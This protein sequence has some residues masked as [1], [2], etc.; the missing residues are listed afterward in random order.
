MVVIK[1]LLSLCLVSYWFITVKLNVIW[2]FG[3]QAFELRSRGILGLEKLR[4]EWMD[5]FLKNYGLRS[6]NRIKCWARIPGLEERLSNDFE[7]LHSMQSLFNS[8]C[9]N[10]L[11]PSPRDLQG[12]KNRNDWLRGRHLGLVT[13]DSFP[14]GDRALRVLR[15]HRSIFKT[16]GLSLGNSLLSCVQAEL[17]LLQMQLETTIFD[18]LLPVSS[19][20][21][22]SS[23]TE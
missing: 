10:I 11:L 12:N 15:F 2:T 18:L 6:K 5:S 4:K 21:V 19:Y 13:A 3:L 16:L 17:H 1:K 23:F 9:T 7:I 8:A 14:S 20:N 22:A